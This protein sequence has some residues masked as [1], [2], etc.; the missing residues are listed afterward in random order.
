MSF[1]IIKQTDHNGCIAACA[2]SVMQYLE[3]PG[4]WNEDCILNMNLHPLS[5]GFDTLKSFI[6]KIGLLDG[7][8]IKVINNNIDFKQYIIEKNSNN[9]PLLCPTQN[10]I[11]S[12]P[13]FPV[14]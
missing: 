5:T 7:W 13:L 10:P 2:A 3:I 9:M 14:K 1:S 8:R 4:H 6:D 11:A 12:F